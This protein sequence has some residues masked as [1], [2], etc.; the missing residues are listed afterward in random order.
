MLL[1]KKYC[2]IKLNYKVN[3]EQ[4]KILFNKITLYI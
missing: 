1:D 2:L 3:K 4:K